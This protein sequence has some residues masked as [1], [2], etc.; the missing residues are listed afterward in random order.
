MRASLLLLLAVLMGGT[1][2]A[3]PRKDKRQEK[4]ERIHAQKIAFISTE[5]DLTSEEAQKFWPIYNEYEAEIE[6]VRTE[7]KK[8]MKELRKSEDLSDDRA[9]ELFELIFGTEKKESDIRLAYLQKFSTVLGKGKAAKVFIAEEKFR[10]EL[11]DKLKKNRQG[12]P[13]DG[14]PPGGG[15]RP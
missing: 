13:H 10:R 3:Q 1:A 2:F 5:L 15:G 6:A 4:R 11:L 7:R 12:P 9:Y 14:P 8:Y